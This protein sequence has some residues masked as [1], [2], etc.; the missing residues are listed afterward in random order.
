LVE[1]GVDL[2]LVAEEERG[3]RKSVPAAREEED[4]VNSE[5][6]SLGESWLM[7][8]GDMRLVM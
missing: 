2:D 6:V 4:K 1:V 5:G 8:E 7:A 3:G